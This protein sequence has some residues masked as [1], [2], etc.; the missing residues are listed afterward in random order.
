[1]LEFATFIFS[2]LITWELLN[3]A[4]LSGS[5]SLL[6]AESYIRQR[7][8]PYAIYPLRTAIVLFCLFLIAFVGLAIWSVSYKPAV[9]NW[10]WLS[11]IPS[12][13]S[14][15]LLVWPIAVICAFMHTKFRDFSQVMALVTQAIYYLSP[16]FLY[17]SIL[18]AGHL[19]YLVDYN[20]IAHVLNLIRA[21][22]LEGYFPS[23]GDY[24]YT[25]GTALAF[26]LIAAWKIR[27]EEAT[28]I[29][30]F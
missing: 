12:F 3:G 20:P 13:A 9:F 17:P 1:V 16:V 8:L 14:L 27:R 30:Y 22:L 21:P 5:I 15:F 24:L 25:L 23:P 2:G 6:S 26:G 4:V 11:L 28:L 29:F 10:S 7:K 19:D 18:R